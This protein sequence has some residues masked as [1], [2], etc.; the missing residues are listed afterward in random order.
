VDK[1][2]KPKLIARTLKP[3]TLESSLEALLV[4]TTSNSSFF[5]R[6][7]F[8]MPRINPKTWRL[9]VEGAVSRPLSLSL[10]ELKAMP[11]ITQA[12]LL[13]CAGN[14]RV[15]LDVPEGVQWNLGAVGCASWTGVPLR[16]VL[17]RAGMRKSAVDVVL[18]GADHGT[19]EKP[20]KPKSEIHFARSI[21]VA[22]ARKSEVLLAYQMNG[23]PLPPAHGAPLRIIV[24]G[25]Y[26]VA[27]VKWLNRITVLEETFRGYFQTVDYACWK[28]GE[29][30]SPERAPITEMFIKSEIARPATHEKIVAGSPYRVRGASWTSGARIKTVEV[31][32]DA[33]ES[34]NIAK[35]AQEPPDHAWRLWEWNWKPPVPGKYTLMSRATDTRGRIQPSAHDENYESYAIHHTLPIHVDVI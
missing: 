10:R 14:G 30:N 16:E 1:I 12:C 25:W 20:A 33:G 26:G 35:L 13:E 17:A 15:F 8:P 9:R 4:P 32:T 29:K 7:H 18:Q 23:A 28:A 27:A 11:S 2:N 31:S 24:P 6:N 19:P 22:V 3:I 34:W 21:P 5:V